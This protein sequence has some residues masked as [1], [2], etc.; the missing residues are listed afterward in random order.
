[1]PTDPTAID[2][3]LLRLSEYVDKQPWV[4]SWISEQSDVDAE[5][6]E[7]LRT[8]P[9]IIHPSMI[10]FPPSCLVAA[11]TGLVCPAPGMVGIVTSWAEKGQIGVRDRPDGEVLARCHPEWLEVIA[12]RHPF[13]PDYMKL[14][15]AELAGG[16]PS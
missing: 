9:E 4:N 13:T 8:R 14:F 10:K 12:C 16:A 6:Y 5:V 11:N 3:D 1:M 7:W 15:L 2:Q